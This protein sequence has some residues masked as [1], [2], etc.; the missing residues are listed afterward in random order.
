MI[1]ITIIRLWSLRLFKSHYFESMKTVS[2]IDITKKNEQN[3]YGGCKLN[4]KIY[5]KILYNA[6]CNG[7]ATLFAQTIAPFQMIYTACNRINK[8]ATLFVVV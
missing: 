3:H 6:V 1:I 2:E 4:C 8:A 7:K 5:I